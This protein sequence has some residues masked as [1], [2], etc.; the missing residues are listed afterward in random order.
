MRSWTLACL[1]T[2]SLFSLSEAVKKED[3]KTCS[4]SSFCKRNRA[5]ADSAAADAQW[6]S[7]YTLVKD[8]IRF[9]NN[10]MTADIHN[11][12][13]N[14]VLV[15][16]LQVLSD[17]TVRVR[18]DEKSPIRPR[19]KDHAQFTLVDDAKP[20]KPF[21]SG[22]NT[23]GIVKITLDAEG[24]RKVLVTPSPLRVDFLLNEE[25]VVTLNDRGFFNIEHLRTKETH[26]P[27]MVMQK[28]EDGTETEVE[29][30][31][32]KGIWEE[33]FKSWTDS[34]PHGPVSI[35]M[36]ISFHGFNHVYGIPV[37]PFHCIFMFCRFPRIISL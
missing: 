32:E 2:L 11:T 22:K 37:S 27:K 4:Q 25:P 17:N 14:N 20:I 31:D 34:K 28:N 18:M 19:Y 6:T 8:S 36:D 30:E 12:D 26:K 7:P 10:F 15:M 5:L 21:K 29:S 24:T 1:A 9:S 33:T 35:G 23:D 3:F 13:T 16:E